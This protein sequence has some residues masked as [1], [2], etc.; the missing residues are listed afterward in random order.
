MAHEAVIKGRIDIFFANNVTI[1][2]F[3]IER[4]VPNQGP[5]IKIGAWHTDQQT[6]GVSDH[7]VE[8]IKILDNII[9]GQNL[10]TEDVKNAGIHITN[11]SVEVHKNHIKGN[12]GNGIFVDANTVAVALSEICILIEHNVI[13]NNRTGINFNTPI[14]SVFNDSYV[15]IVEN[16]FIDNTA[17]GISIGA[18][19]TKFV[20]E[21]NIFDGNARSHFSDRRYTYENEE[22]EIS[23]GK[24]DIISGNTI[25]GFYEWKDAGDRWLLEPK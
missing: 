9:D 19:P 21:D 17:H 24:D 23:P 12:K 22:Y 25:I 6:Y 13:E 8:G 3:K 2:N 11:S 14:T 16:E 10:G 15:D 18:V 4:V 20:I 7:G 5:S 1:K